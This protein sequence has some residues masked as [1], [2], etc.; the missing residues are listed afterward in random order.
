MKTNQSLNAAPKSTY[1]MLIRSEEKERSLFETA[2][3]SLLVLS[4][5]IGICQFAALRIPTPF[6]SPEPTSVAAQAEVVS[7]G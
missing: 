5:V 6:A 2:I 1:S 7:H 3:Y 4:V